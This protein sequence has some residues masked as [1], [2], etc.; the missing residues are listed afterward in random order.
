MSFSSFFAANY[1][2]HWCSLLKKSEGPFARCHSVIDPSE[3]YKVLQSCTL[4]SS[5]LFQV[6]DTDDT[7]SLKCFRHY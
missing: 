3:Y 7:S 5:A 1:A 6:D 2:E 4:F